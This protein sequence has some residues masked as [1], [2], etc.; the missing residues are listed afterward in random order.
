MHPKR[1]LALET[2]EDLSLTDE[3]V[4]EGWHWCRDW[5]GMLVGPGMPEVDCC[6]CRQPKCPTCED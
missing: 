1:Y 6:T 5:D 3:E 4:K 2:H